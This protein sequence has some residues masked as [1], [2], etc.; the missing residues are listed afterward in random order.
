MKKQQLSF[1][2]HKKLGQDLANLSLFFG[3]LTGELSRRY[4]KS[5]R[6]SKC[7]G[8]IYQK[9]MRLRSDM[10]A[11]LFSGHPIEATTKVYY[12]MEQ[13]G[14]IQP[15]DLAWLIKEENEGRVYL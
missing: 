4:G 13:L 9:L 12:P 15:P 14:E 2:Q 7:A 8:S 11:P 3:V 6:P 10:E 5:S 1:A